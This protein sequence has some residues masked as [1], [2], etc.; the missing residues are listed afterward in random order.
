MQKPTTA[1][2]AA[3]F[4]A[5]ILQGQLPQDPLV[6]RPVRYDLAV[7]VDFT[8][9]QIEGT[10]RIQ[11]RNENSRPVSEASFILY[12]LMSVRDVRD[13]KGS[14]M[15]FQQAVVA[16]EDFEKFQGNHVRVPLVPALA[17]GKETT[18]ELRY[19]GYLVG[20]AETGMLYVQDRVDSAYTLLREDA[21]AYPTIGYPSLGARR[22]AGLPTYE[23]TAR[24][25][26]P[27]T[28]T[29]A[30]G[31][32]LVSR[33]SE[34]V[35]TTFVY[36]SVKPSWR[37]DFAIAPFR[38]LRRGTLT[39]FH[40]PEDSSGAQRILGAMTETMA[41]YARWFGPLKGEPPFTVIE[42]PDGWGSQADVT[43]I[44]QAAAAFRDPKREYEL[45]HELSHLWNVPSADKPS[46]RWNEGLA[47]F[48]EDVTTD[49]LHARA[50]TDS[51]AMRLATWLAGRLR[52]DSGL[53]S[54][55][56]ADYGKREMT[57][58]AYTVGS[59]MFYSLYRVLGHDTFIRL[60]GDYYRAH[61]AS[62][63]STDDFVRLA[64][65][66]SPVDLTALFGDWLYSTRW[67]EMVRGA[68][69]PQDLYK[70]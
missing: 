9:E 8:K 69:S 52:G 36:R 50:T 63:G 29:V 18:I 42:I 5:S 1:I 45:Y 51:S 26:V 38:M 22:R 67:S 17:P 62:T 31:G 37:M 35:T 7:R 11:L 20:Y 44:L 10:A 27:A 19:G 23:Y 40:L 61:G 28:H 54:V 58:Y 47:T 70:K 4:A 30:N 34:G 56:P 53:S 55:P 68:K 25:T 48:L 24:I 41:L 2:V 32:E 12:R 65:S 57:G 15:S 43:S 6:L 39:V 14:A 46:P 13:A 21:S 59:L 60:I 49:S 33:T 66:L 16:F 3:F 64:K